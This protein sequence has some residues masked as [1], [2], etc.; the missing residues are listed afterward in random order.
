MHA[1]IPAL[2]RLRQADLCSLRLRPAWSTKHVPRQ[3]GLATLRSPV[4]KKQQQKSPYT[5]IFEDEKKYK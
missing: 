2:G 5:V 1:F 3:Q 4:S